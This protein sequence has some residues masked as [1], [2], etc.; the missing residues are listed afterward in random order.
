MHNGSAEDFE[1]SCGGSI[2]SIPTNFNNVRVGMVRNTSNS[3]R[4]TIQPCMSDPDESGPDRVGLIL[5]AVGDSGST[6]ALQALGKS[7]IL[8]RSTNLN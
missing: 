8:L 5:W 7:S 4:E 1:S 6:G 3:V 2:P